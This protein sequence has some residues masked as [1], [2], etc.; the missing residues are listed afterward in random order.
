MNLLEQQRIA[1]V[2]TDKQN[3]EILEEY[4]ARNGAT[5]LYFSN[6]SS[7]IEVL[8]LHELDLILVEIKPEDIQN[9]EFIRTLNQRFP[10]PIIF[11]MATADNMDKAISSLDESDYWYLKKPFKLNELGKLLEKALEFSQLH[12]KLHYLDKQTDQNRYESIFAGTSFA[13]RNVVNRIQTV[14]PSQSNI[15]IIGETGTGK[16]TAARSIH[17]KSSRVNAPFIKVNCQI[18]P[19]YELDEILFGKYIDTGKRMGSVKRGF[20]EEAHN[21]TILL[22]EVAKLPLSIQTKLL[23]VIQD[24]E[25]LPAEGFELRNVNV[26]VIATTTHNLEN[27]VIQGRFRQDLYFRLNVIPIRIP[28]LRERIEDITELSKYFTARYSNEFGSRVHGITDEAIGLLKTCS[29]RGNAR[30]LQNAIEHAVLLSKNELLNESDFAF[31]VDEKKHNQKN[32]LTGTH[33][34]SLDEIEKSHILTVLAENNYNRTRTA[35]ALSISIRTLRNKLSEYRKE[36]TKV[37]LK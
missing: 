24:G 30:E 18:Y 9:L 20:F 11:L 15:L 27:E 1:V 32:K 3:L 13:I 7:A 23:R 5:G 6:V 16:E 17:S 28:P 22:E 19:D 26:R 31:L 29:W 8:D 36:G 25:I 14:A 12:W 34:T 10:Q 35:A 21:G 2:D 33:T 37:D 4:F